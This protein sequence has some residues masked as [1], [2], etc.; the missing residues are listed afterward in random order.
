MDKLLAVLSFHTCLAY[1]DD[2]IFFSSS[3]HDH[4]THLHTVFSCIIMAGLKLNPP[5]C[6]LA[7]DSV[8]FLG[9]MVSRNRISAD[10]S[11]HQAI[12]DIPPPITPMQVK[13]FRGLAGYH[14]SFVTNFST[15]ACPLD[16]LVMK[17]SISFSSG[18]PLPSLHLLPSNLSLRHHPPLLTISSPSTFGCTQMHR[19]KG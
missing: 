19:R 2:I 15:I 5:K 1:I 14:H 6:A 4:L 11:L 3:W 12:A 7:C 18:P 10:P 9:H 8:P 16:A 17:D 13:L